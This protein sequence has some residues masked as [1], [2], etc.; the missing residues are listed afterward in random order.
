MPLPPLKNFRMQNFNV[1]SS[2]CLKLLQVTLSNTH[3]SENKDR[4]KTAKLV[5]KMWCFSYQQLPFT[6]SNFLVTDYFLVDMDLIL[7]LLLL[8]LLVIVVLLVCLLSMYIIHIETWSKYLW[9]GEYGQDIQLQLPVK[10]CIY[11]GR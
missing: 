6:L 8:L 11:V 2:S 3:T 9:A 4:P 5:Y 7:I 1:I 10:K